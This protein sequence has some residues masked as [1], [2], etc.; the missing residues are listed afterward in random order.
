MLE[1]KNASRVATFSSRYGS[2]IPIAGKLF[3][4]YIYFNDHSSRYIIACNQSSVGGN[5][6][7]FTRHRSEKRRRNTPRGC[8]RKREKRRER[9]RE[10]GGGRE[11]KKEEDNPIVR[12]FARTFPRVSVRR[13]SRSIFIDRCE[14][15]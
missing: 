14:A 11:R 8:W 7:A 10:R 12:T 4:A 1:T 15:N 13:V 6:P 5:I 3:I 9:E 2:I